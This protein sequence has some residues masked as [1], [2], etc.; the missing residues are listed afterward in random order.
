MKNRKTSAPEVDLNS[1]FHINEKG[2]KVSGTGHLLKLMYT[3]VGSKKEY[4]RRQQEIGE[5][6][7]AKKALEEVMPL[8]ERATRIIEAQ[9]EEK[10]LENRK[11]IRI[12]PKQKNA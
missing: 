11:H 4:D 9:E 5:Y 2:Q 8:L 7:G 3:D 1:T 6:R 12:V 10:A